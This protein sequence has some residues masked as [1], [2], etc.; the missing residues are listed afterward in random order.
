MPTFARADKSVETLAAKSYAAGLKVLKA[1][2]PNTLDG[3][4]KTKSPAQRKGFVAAIRY[5]VENSKTKNSKT[6]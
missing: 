2:E 6:P 4:W 1:A 5:A 3:G